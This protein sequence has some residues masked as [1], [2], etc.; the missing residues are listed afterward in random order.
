MPHHAAGHL[1]APKRHE[2]THHNPRGCRSTTHA[3]DSN[4][5]AGLWSKSGQRRTPTPPGKQKQ[6]TNAV[7][8]TGP[9]R[10]RALGLT[11]Q[12]RTPATCS[13][14]TYTSKGQHVFSEGSTHNVRRTSAGRRQVQNKKKRR[15][16]SRDLCP[17]HAATTGEGAKARLP[18]D[19]GLGKKKGGAGTERGQGP[20]SRGRKSTAR[21]WSAAV[22]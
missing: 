9:A 11:K 14:T 7:L 22:R 17:T 15:G 8:V 12:Q 21:R 2:R 18:Q 1:T 19:E 13:L 6:N 5:G 4:S 3:A 20:T 10:E 16:M